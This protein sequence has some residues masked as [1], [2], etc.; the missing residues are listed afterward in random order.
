M[1][2]RIRLP[3]LTYLVGAL[4]SA[5]SVSAQSAPAGGK[6]D[7]I[8]KSRAALAKGTSRVIL[9]AVNGQSVAS[10]DKTVRQAG[11]VPGRVLSIIDSQVA[12]V[13]NAALNGLAHNPHVQRISYDRAIAGSMERTGPTVGATAVRQQYGYDGSGVGVAIIDSGIT[14]WHDDLGDAALGTQ[15]VDRFVD[16]V[17]G[18]ALSYDD[19]GHGTH[20]A[21]IIAGNGYDSGGLRSGIAPGSHLVVLK[22]LDKTGSGR[23]SDVIAALD[24][25]V[26]HNAELNVR[27]CNLSVATA[28]FESYNT[29][30]LT[31]AALEAVKANIVVVA[32][33]GNNGR[34]PTGKM[35]YGGITAPGNAPWVLTVGASSHM[36]T[37][38]PTDDTIAAF[39]SRGPTA[40]DNSAK[41]DLVAPGVGIESLSDPNSAMY[42]IYSSYLLNGTVS[43]SFVPYLSLSGTSMATPVVAGTVALMLQANPALTPNAVKAILQYTSRPTSGYDSVT[44]GTGF[45]NAKGAVDLARYFANPAAGAYP[46]APEWTANILWGNR[47]I[48]GGRLAADANAWS[49]DVLW[50]AP[51]TASGQQVEWGA[52][53]A[54]ADCSTGTTSSQWDA[55][56]PSR[57]VVWGNKCKGADCT[58]SWTISGVNSGGDIVVWGTSDGDIVVWGTSDGDIVVW[59]TSGPDIVVWGTACTDSSCAPVIWNRQ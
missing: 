38:D 47:L 6:L 36:G 8:V 2:K 15:R 19:Y 30:P 24:Y 46:A 35:Q 37:I 22:A 58:G 21:G 32:A 3:L 56:A 44:A 43:T 11:G 23:I 55:T 5:A 28:V 17:G 31:L 42:S 9:R 49:T 10:L 16:F 53:C 41:P 14:S 26:A 39:S 57:N 59:G 7:S 52:A 25:L 27:V 33:A 50:G 29:D 18:Q 54:T 4:L 45:L 13:P 1:V 48:R 12:T 34:G 40:L 20:V 51:V